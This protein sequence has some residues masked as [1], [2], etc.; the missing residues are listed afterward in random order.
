MTK[1]EA[2]HFK[3]G[4]YLGKTGWIDDDAKGLD[5][6]VWVYVDNWK[7]NRC[8]I[9]HTQVYLVSFWELPIHNDDVGL[10]P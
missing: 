5:T 8:S 4:T 7:G 10:G 9:K 6:M 2:I 1:G 3:K